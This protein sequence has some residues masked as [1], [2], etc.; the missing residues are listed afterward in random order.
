MA[1]T[2]A[3][4]VPFKEW[5]CGYSLVSVAQSQIRM[6]LQNGY[7]VRIICYT[8]ASPWINHKHISYR[9]T[10]PSYPFSPHRKLPGEFK[11]RVLEIAK[12]LEKNLKGVDYVITHDFL[13]LDSFVVY[14]AAFRLVARRKPHIRWLHWCHSGSI[15]KPKRIPVYPQSLR[16]QPL[17]KLAKL[18]TVAHTHRR[19]FSRQY[20]IPLTQVAVVHNARF[21]Q[22]FLK[23]NAATWRMIKKMELAKADIIAVMPSPLSRRT[24]QHEICVYLTAALKELG[25]S[26]RMIFTNSFARPSNKTE[27]FVLMELRWLA[28]ELGLSE[29]EIIFTSALG[30]HMHES[31][32]ENIVRDLFLISNVFIF[33]TLGEA[34]SL[35]LQEAALLKNVCILNKNVPALKEI[36]GK[37]ALWLNFKSLDRELLRNYGK[38]GVCSPQTLR[39][40]YQKK[41]PIYLKQAKKILKA[42]DQ[43]FSVKLQTEVR[44]HYNEEAI[45]QK[46]LKPL[47]P[48]G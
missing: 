19:N 15:G 48:Q 43:N 35:A 36:A 6:L 26:V 46:Q 40:F 13:F 22:N 31:C 9:A 17:P 12:I 11:R 30:K 23:L 42:L 8:K 32:P 41:R 20:R 24:K 14:N 34:C 4:A 3:I 10:L 38:K 5:N 37:N 33:P 25:K 28:H 2:I 29:K 47:L 45:F 7:K 1:V 18:I 16:F 21:N 27:Q 44:Q 39:N